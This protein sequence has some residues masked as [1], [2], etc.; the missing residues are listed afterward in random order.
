MRLFSPFRFVWALQLSLLKTLP[1]K[2]RLN[3]MQKWT[4]PNT[5][6]AEHWLRA[7]RILEKLPS[8][9][10]S[11]TTITQVI[12]H[13]N[14]HRFESFME[15][16]IVEKTF[17]SISITIEHGRDCTDAEIACITVHPEECHSKKTEIFSL[18]IKCRKCRRT[19]RHCHLLMACMKLQ[20]S[21]RHA[22]E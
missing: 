3:Y 13:A 1:I 2:S 16:N 12:S 9:F 8:E 17:K 7:V 6:Y 11:R 10:L 4:R 20:L 14:A 15:Q 21:G 18:W 5:L 22:S 19:C